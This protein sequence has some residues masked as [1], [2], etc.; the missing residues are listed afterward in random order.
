MTDTNLR[1]FATHAEGCGD[2]GQLHCG[3]G[4]DAALA[5]IDEMTG[6]YDD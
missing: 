3:C 1:P 5:Y 2:H 6:G 4:L